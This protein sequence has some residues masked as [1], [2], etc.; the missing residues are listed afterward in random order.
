VFW[1]TALVRLT[2]EFSLYATAKPP[3]SSLALLMRFPDE[4]RPRLFLRE[5]LARLR[6]CEAKVALELVFTTI[7]IFIFLDFG[8]YLMAT[9]SLSAPICG[10][11]L[12][13]QLMRSHQAERLLAL[14]SADSA[15]NTLIRVA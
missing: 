6:F 14:I 4:R 12:I 9:T 10:V 8:F 13:A 3:A 15:Q 11:K 7:G 2:L 5:S 1:I